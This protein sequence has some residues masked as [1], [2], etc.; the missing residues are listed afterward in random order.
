[1]SSASASITSP[2]SDYQLEDAKYIPLVVIGCM[3]SFLSVFGSCGVM[4]M[5]WQDKDFSKDLQSRLLFALS[6]CEALFSLST[7]WS[8][9]LTPAFVGMPGSIGTFSSCSFIG[10]AFMT[11][12]LM[13]ACYSGSL[14]LYYYLVVR[15]NWK[16]HDFASW[17]WEPILH[18]VAIL[19]PLLITT[20]A[21]STQS[22]NPIGL[23][24]QLC[25]LMVWPWQCEETDTIPCTRS[26]PE[27]V[28][29]LTLAMFA[30]QGF[31]TILGL[32]CTVLVWKTVRQTLRRSVHRTMDSQQTQARMRQVRIQATLYS[33]AHLNTFLWP[34]MCMILSA[35]LHPADVKVAIQT[36][37]FYT[38][39]FLTWTLFPLQG[40]FNFFIY[41]RVKAREWRML[42]PEQ[43]SFWVYRQVLNGT[44]LP[45]GGGR[46]SS[47]NTSRNN[48]RSVSRLCGSTEP[49]S[50]P[51][52]TSE[53]AMMRSNNNPQ[54]HNNKSE[55]HDLSECNQSTTTTTPIPVL[56][57][58]VKMEEQS[59][60][61]STEHVVLSNSE[62]NPQK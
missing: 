56:D 35:S 27:I 17:R 60:V 45:R 1:M 42:Q 21:A 62:P 12:N 25:L 41:T 38:L 19:L 52:S 5:S 57:A 43:S 2:Y 61:D 8:P 13:T 31:F 44:E 53:H 16:D 33:L 50:A 14:S 4:Y 15:R 6:L 39:V 32:I 18:A 54:Q 59:S 36:P 3:G 11:G 26:S 29:L 30:Y 10:F 37:G 23:Q 48:K 51:W 40:V 55:H 7:F 28:G 22:I 58:S 34:L 9:F 20:V 46:R 49:I 47:S 24:S